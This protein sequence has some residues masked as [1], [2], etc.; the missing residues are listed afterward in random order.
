[1]SKK[2][3][4]IVKWLYIYIF[5]H[6][7]NIQWNPARK[8]VSVARWRVVDDGR[9]FTYLH[10]STWRNSRR[11]M[12]CYSWRNW[13]CNSVP[14]K[15]SFKLVKRKLVEFIFYLVSV[16]LYCARKRKFAGS[17]TDG[18]IGIL[19]CITFPAA[20]WPWIWL[21]LQ[22]KC[23]SGIFLEGKGGRCVGQPT[24]TQSCADCL[25]I[26]QHQPHET[27]RASNRPVPLLPLHALPVTFNLQDRKL[28]QG[29]KWVK[30]T[31]SSYSL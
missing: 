31:S 6:D 21:S 29:C 8:S 27:L 17:I 20:I 19:Y 24:L 9:L 3:G 11:H 26:W 16:T 28:F 13:Q 4:E 22:Q 2:F 5:S 7:R 10:S 23:I 12:L 25:E 14:M 18:V 15:T 1:M 30:E